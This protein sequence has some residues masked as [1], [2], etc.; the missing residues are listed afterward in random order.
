MRV[1]LIMIGEIKGRPKS[2][3]LEIWICKEDKNHI[4]MLLTETNGHL[5]ENPTNSMI[6][7]E[8]TKLQEQLKRLAQDNE[9]ILRGEP[10]NNEELKLL[11]HLKGVDLLL[12][13]DKLTVKAAQVGMLEYLDLELTKANQHH[14]RVRVLKGRFKIVMLESFQKAE[15]IWGQS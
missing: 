15:E 5:E 2:D 3:R 6:K 9:L 11:S 8:K 7:I 4:F 1:D 14:H 10:I 13:K 12:G